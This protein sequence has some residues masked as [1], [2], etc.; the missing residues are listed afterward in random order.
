ML[1]LDDMASTYLVTD[2]LAFIKCYL[3]VTKSIT[4]F[5]NYKV[6]M[7]YS[8]DGVGITGNLIENS[9]IEPFLIL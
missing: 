1:H 9:K 5:L 2:A 6:N 3:I 4:H 8:T 7:D